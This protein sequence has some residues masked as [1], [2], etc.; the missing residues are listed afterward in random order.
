ML[1]RVV[2]LVL[3]A[4]IYGCS[5][6]P[7]ALTPPELRPTAA[8]AEAIALYD[9]D[10]S[11]DLSHDE[12]QACP[13]MLSAIETYDRDGDE[14]I[15]KD[16]ITAR[17]QEFAESRVALTQLVAVV[18]LDKR[19]LEGATVKFVPETYLGS[20]IKTALG[21]TG[22]SGGSMM[23][24]DD[25]DLPSNQAGLVGIQ[26]GTYRVEITHPEI[27]IPPEYNTDTTLGYDS[28]PG[29]LS[30]TFDLKAR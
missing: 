22:R 5:G 1:L 9:K 14:K 26:L 29:N 21:T 20:S 7:P 23:D 2:C 13:G 30:V 16:E 25:S 4:L 3:M 10:G 15:S 8:A 18:R 6:G 11:G 19:P 17:L 24:V 12:L 27:S 28:Q